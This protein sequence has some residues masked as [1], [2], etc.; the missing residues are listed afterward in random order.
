MKTQKNQAKQ[1]L[2][3]T[4]FT[5]SKPTFTIPNISDSFKFKIYLALKNW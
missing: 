5:P 3:I 2:F 4:S 1:C